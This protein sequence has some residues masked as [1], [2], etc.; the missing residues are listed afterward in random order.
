KE[1][2]Q[3]A[4]IKAAGE[5]FDAVVVAPALS[6]AGPRAQLEALCELFLVHVGN[7]TFPGGCFFAAAAADLATPPGQVRQSIAD[8]QD[9]WQ[10]QLTDLIVKAQDAGEISATADPDQLFFELNSLMLQANSSFVM[11]GDVVALDRARHGIAQRLDQAGRT[12]TP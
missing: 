2:L 1:E 9:R 6:R 8:F 7:R 4:T 11:H 5:I 12:S 3:L 10:T